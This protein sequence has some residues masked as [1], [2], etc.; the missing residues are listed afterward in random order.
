MCRNVYSSRRPQSDNNTRWLTCGYCDIVHSSELRQRDAYDTELEQ[1]LIAVKDERDRAVE[2]LINAKLELV[3]TRERLASAQSE[4]DKL[5][6]Q[7]SRCVHSIP[8][9][10]SDKMVLIDGAEI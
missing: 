5:I 8:N 7:L 3:A 2:E 1:E 4:S 6:A 10:P 9:H